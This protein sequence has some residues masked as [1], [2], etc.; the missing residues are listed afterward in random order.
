VQD[1]ARVEA[2]LLA[3]VE[4]RAPVE[5]KVRA[6][7][8][9]RVEVRVELKAPRVDRWMSARPRG[10]MPSTVNFKGFCSN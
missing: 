4:H 10:R 8:E 7:V 6:P 5:G 1:K 3:P 9:D 2:K